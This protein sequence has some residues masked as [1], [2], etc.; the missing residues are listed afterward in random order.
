LAIFA[1]S[2]KMA[3]MSS[4]PRSS[5]ACP[6]T[7]IVATILHSLARSDRAAIVTPSHS[8]TW[9]EWIASVEQLVER[10][11]RLR[12]AQIGLC[13][14]PSGKS[15]ALLL[16]LSWLDCDLF[17]HDAGMSKPAIAEL[18][19]R[20]QLDA[21]ID[22]ASEDDGGECTSATPSTGRGEVTIFTSG[23]TGQPKPV[24]HDW[25][26]LTRPVRKTNITSP[27][28]WL[29]TYRPHL[30]AGLQVFLHCLLNRETLVLP[31]PGTSVD[32]L[33]ELMR[34]SLVTSVSAT[35]SYWRRLI[36]QG[37]PALLK[38]IPLEQIT[39]GGEIA[40]EKLLAALDRFYPEARLVHIYATSELGRCFSVKDR[41][42]GFPSRFLDAP[43]DDGVELK[44]ED[45]E[46]HVR[47]ANAMIG[48]GSS[49]DVGSREADWLPTGDLIEQVGDRCFFVGRRNDVINVGGNKVQPLRVEHV[50]QVVPGVRDVRVFSR[51]SSLVGHMVACE[52]VPEPGLEPED[53]RQAILKTCL[54]RLDS[55][56][57]PRF[58]QAVSTIAL[59][60]AEKK[61]RK[62]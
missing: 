21:A 51:S 52:F 12:G 49:S 3:S 14:R 29:L 37:G 54:E 17:L 50:I 43:S 4:Q 53:I 26:S 8:V 19:D 38:S 16:A 47:S 35:P 1:R 32:S 23:S 13:L 31:E 5:G 48:D 11:H 44:L 45:G 56:E 60:D 40:D 10:Y 24:R 46:L 33:V 22:P 39:L 15:Y 57:R 41:R 58:V 36:T 2:I 27:Q 30:Y 28:R 7:E 6:T 62:P 42:A 59:S 18:I 34:R 20:C 61:I 55:H 9:A 25:N